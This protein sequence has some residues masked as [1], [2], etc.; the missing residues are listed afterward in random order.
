MQ[1]KCVDIFLKSIQTV[2]SC[3]LRSNIEWQPAH[4]AKVVGLYQWCDLMVQFIANTE[5]LR[6]TV[7][8]KTDTGR[9]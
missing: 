8:N 2:R 1:V 6:L 5:G 9:K 7:N 3:N 4:S